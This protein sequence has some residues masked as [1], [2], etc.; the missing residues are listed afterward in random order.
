MKRIQRAGFV[1]KELGT[2]SS[3]KLTSGAVEG[4]SSR[5]NGRIACL[6]IYNTA[7][8]DEEVKVVSQDLECPHEPGKIGGDCCGDSV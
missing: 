3:L 4:N 2:G 5:Y 6:R 1:A 7:L 8:T